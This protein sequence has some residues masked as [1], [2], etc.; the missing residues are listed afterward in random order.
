MT[1]HKSPLDAFLYTAL[2]SDQLKV[3]LTAKHPIEVQKPGKLIFVHN[4]ATQVF[5][6]H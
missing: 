5:L 4:S 1:L 6:V 3:S 2:M